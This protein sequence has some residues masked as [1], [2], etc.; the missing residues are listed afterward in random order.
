MVSG[1]EFQD[2]VKLNFN[3]VSALA[4]QMEKLALRARQKALPSAST[5]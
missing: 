1:E 3:C 5:V 4:G 2:G